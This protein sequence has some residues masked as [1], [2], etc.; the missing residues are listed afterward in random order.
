MLEQDDRS[1]RKILLVVLSTVG[2]ILL[3]L[4]IMVSVLLFHQYRSK[5]NYFRYV[6]K[7]YISLF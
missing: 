7:N 2:A 1:D 4:A 3:L 6:V 5:M